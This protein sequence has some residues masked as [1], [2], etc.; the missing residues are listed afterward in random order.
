[1]SE[2]TS[3]PCPRPT[4]FLASGSPRRSVMLEA[5]GVEFCCGG[6]EIDERPRGEAA[7]AFAKRLAREKAQAGRALGR[8]DWVL[9]SDT[10]VVVDGVPLGKP[11]DV[12]E[13]ASMLL[14]L[15]GRSH[16]VLT[17]W[18]LYGPDGPGADREGLS[19]TKVRF[20]EISAAEAR[21]YAATGE[22]LDK[23]GGYGIQGGAAAFVEG[24][25]GDLDGVIGLPLRAVLSTL[26]RCGVWAAPSPIA[27]NLG[28]VRGRMAAA[29]QAAGRPIGSTTLIAATKGHD[30]TALEALASAG[31]R[32]F[33]ESYVQ[34][35]QAKKSDFEVGAEVDSER[36]EWHF[37][38]RVQR[39][40]ARLIA[41]A[42]RVHGIAS[43][44]AARAIGAAAQSAGR[45]VPILLQINIDAEPGKGGVTV[46]DALP[47]A[48][49]IAAVD[50]V[51]LD[52][53][54]ALPKP[55]PMFETR[56]AFKRMRTL[57]QTLGQGGLDLP[58]LS[59]GMS[60]DFPLA[61]AQ[62]ATFI[63][64]GTALLGPR[65]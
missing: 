20:R 29:E 28:V 42:A 60:G 14:R 12:A 7:P 65:R 46:A 37:I 56:S 22:P 19:E 41:G 2:P 15:S 47:V 5:A 25:D 23:A 4:L 57:Q 53:L 38:G 49:D 34:E 3:A 31:L 50:G 48:Q 27:L 52:G 54:M 11:R 9:G 59:M 64:V 1:M 30:Q 44:R 17:A 45:T 21:A 26:A 8:A 35:W 40:K 58:E 24:F 63:R 39:N 13:A 51:S 6:V 18:A 62:G 43:V 32:R 55:G 10:I 36:A 61:I 33:G 16:S